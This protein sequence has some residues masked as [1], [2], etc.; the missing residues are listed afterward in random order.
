[1]TALQLTI[2]A[3]TLLTNAFFVGAEFALIAVRRS[4]IEPHARKGDK[5]A[6]TVLY[7]LEHLSAMMATAQ[8]GITVS[9]LVL[10]AVA[11]VS[12]LV[13]LHWPL[14]LVIDDAHWADQE[15]LRWLAGFAQHLDE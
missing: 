14:V 2:G 8:L 11:A 3:L 4:Q 10:G 13:T 7:G 1:M 6:P 12:R 5:R 15:S 9:S